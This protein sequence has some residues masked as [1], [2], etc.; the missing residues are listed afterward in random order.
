MRVFSISEVNNQLQQSPHILKEAGPTNAG[1]TASG[2][3][4]RDCLSKCLQQAGAN[5]TTRNAE[6]NVAGTLCGYIQTLNGIP[7]PDPK[8]KVIAS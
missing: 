7:K 5:A 8:R 4:F 6:N 2:N 1:K 3:S